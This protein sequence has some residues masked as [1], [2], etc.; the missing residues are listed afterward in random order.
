MVFSE[1]IPLAGLTTF[2]LGGKAAGVAVCKNLEDIKAALALSRE[3]G[4]PW[5]VIGGGSNLLVNDAGY[6]GIMIK[7]EGKEMSFE[8]TE[9]KEA[10]VGSNR[11]A[12]VESDLKGKVLAIAEAGVVW[13][14]FVEES[15]TLGLWGLENLAGIP[16]SVGGAPVQNIGA[17]GADV[18]DTLAWVEALDTASGELRRFTNKECAF[19]Y[20]ES[21][22]K[23]DPSLIIMRVAFILSKNSIPQI[24]YADLKA[25]AEKG[26]ET[27]ETLTT[28]RAIAHAVREIRAGKF[29][30]LAVSG[31][32]GSFFKNPTLPQTT[33]ETLKAA[34]PELPGYA[35][36]GGM[37]ISLAWILD[38][39]LNLKG[40]VKDHVRLFEKQPLV[41]VAEQGATSHDVDL[42][43]HEIESKVLVAI[44][45]TLEREVR[46]L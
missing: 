26:S 45:I 1:D 33:F 39:V 36:E 10:S 34:Y 12:A 18:S 7:M 42:L 40:Y 43:A 30:D 31:T 44:G 22:F 3:R 27:G 41:I 14:T 46:M 11:E 8:D 4:L 9:D 25:K 6:D 20:R 16:G 35:A 15:I 5:Y 24:S 17:Y 23:H 19:S 29:P 32:A 13:D 38:H 21:L 28:P 37:K 2:K